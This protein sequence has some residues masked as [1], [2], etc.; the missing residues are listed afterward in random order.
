MKFRLKFNIAVE[1]EVEL[2]VQV[3]SLRA[4]IDEIT[5]NL[6]LKFEPTL[7]RQPHPHARVRIARKDDSSALFQ[8]QKSQFNPIPLFL[9]H[10]HILAVVPRKAENGTSES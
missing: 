7:Q 6:T 4:P 10:I 5:M 2:K 3:E 8:S 9:N 1:F